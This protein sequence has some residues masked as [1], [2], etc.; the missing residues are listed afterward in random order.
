MRFVPLL[1]F[2]FCAA[3]LAGCAA[4]PDSA[5]AFVSSTQGTT[6][7]QTGYVTDV[8][9]ITVRGGQNSAIGSA[10]G[11]LL[12]GIAG[13]NIGSGHGRTVATIAGA[14]AGGIAGQHVGKPNS[15]KSVT[16]L[17]VRLD[18]GDM[19]T[20]DIEPGEAFRIG[21]TVKIITNGGNVRITH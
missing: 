10:V 20:Y 19:R 5:P 14:S 1:T 2:S 13:S 3:A 9:D 18:N 8:R 21:D 4:Q 15:G 11:A 12:G 16:K 7:V 6:L 17:T